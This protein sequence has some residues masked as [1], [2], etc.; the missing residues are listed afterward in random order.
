MKLLSKETFLFFILLCLIAPNSWSQIIKT[1]GAP[2]IQNYKR[3]Q[4]GGAHQVWDVLQ[5]S[6]GLVY[7]A[8][9]THLSEFDG[10]KW[11]S[12]KL[13]ERTNLRCLAYHN[14]KLTAED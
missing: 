9:S 5:D 14:S 10:Y 6:V 12:Y 11:R 8:T 13:S 1:Q 4:Y 7:V 2:R 3:F